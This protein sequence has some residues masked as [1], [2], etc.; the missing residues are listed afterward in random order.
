MPIH[1]LHEN[2]YLLPVPYEK[3]LDAF[4][5]LEHVY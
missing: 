3:K 4:M 2:T 5:I 1:A